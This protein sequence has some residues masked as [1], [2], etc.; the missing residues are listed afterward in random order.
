VVALVRPQLFSAPG[1]GLALSSGC[2]TSWWDGSVVRIATWSGRGRPPLRMRHAPYAIDGAT[3]DRWVQLVS[4]ALGEAQL[5]CEVELML[6]SFFEGVTTM[7]M[8]TGWC[9]REA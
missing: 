7:M 3:R 6:H 9:S 4:R 5:P 1:A 2:A 8:K